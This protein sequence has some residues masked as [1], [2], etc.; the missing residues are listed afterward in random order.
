VRKWTR[1]AVLYISY[2]SE[3]SPVKKDQSDSVLIRSEPFSVQNRCKLVIVMALA[4]QT[5]LLVY[6]SGVKGCDVNNLIMSTSRAVLSDQ[7][8]NDQMILSTFV[9]CD[10]TSEQGNHEP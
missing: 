9:F 10:I 1:A 2:I 7:F 6:V 3:N 4:M 5:G 8:I